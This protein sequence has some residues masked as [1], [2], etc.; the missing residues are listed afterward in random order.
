MPGIAAP[1]QELFLLLGL[2]TSLL[3]SSYVG[4]LR[5]AG[6]TEEPGRVFV[7]CAGHAKPP[8]GNTSTDPAGVRASRGVR[9]APK[10]RTKGEETHHPYSIS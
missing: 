3:V 8:P 4:A 10:G 5:S 6:V 9:T 1:L 2:F 7:G